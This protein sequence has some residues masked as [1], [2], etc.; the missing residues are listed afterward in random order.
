MEDLIRRAQRGD[1]DAFV[2]LMEHS[3]TSL[4]RAAM[5][6]LKNPEDAADALQ[7]TALEAWKNLPRLGK[8]KYLSTW[9]TR[10]LL[11][12]C[13]D[14]LRRKKREQPSDK[15][16]EEGRTQDRDETLDVRRAMAALAQSDRLVLT[17]F[18]MNDAPV[19]EIARILDLTEGAVR[20]RLTRA[21]GRFRAAYEQ[22]D[23]QK[24]QQEDRQREERRA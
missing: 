12:N 10:I 20:V 14:I 17:L 2:A 3:K 5:A 21:R 9:L 7:E 24:D 6:V 16:Y 1:Q 23:R 18:Y 8:D 13:C 4:W 15:L 11:Y 19:K 22:K